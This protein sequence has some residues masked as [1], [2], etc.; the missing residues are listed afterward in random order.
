MVG[1]AD[2][3]DHILHTLFFIRMDSVNSIQHKQ[4]VFGLFLQFVQKFKFCFRA[5][6]VC[7][8]HKNACMRGL[9]LFFGHLTMFAE[10]PVQAGTVHHHNPVFQKITFQKQINMI[11]FIGNVIPTGTDYL[12]NDIQVQGRQIPCVAV[13]IVYS[14][15]NFFGSLVFMPQKVD[16]RGGLA[17]KGRQNPPVHQCIQKSGFSGAE[18]AYYYNAEQILLHIFPLHFKRAHIFRIVLVFHI[19]DA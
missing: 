10:H 13:R 11:N 7:T 3:L 8:E 9:D 5:G 19:A 2:G 1:A 14:T 15:S 6:L 18:L 16:G 12:F 4:N 17:G